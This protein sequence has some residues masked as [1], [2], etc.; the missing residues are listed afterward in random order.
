MKFLPRFTLLHSLMA[1]HPSAMMLAW[2]GRVPLV[3]VLA[4]ILFTHL[5]P[6]RPEMPLAMRQSVEKQVSAAMD[7]LAAKTTAA[8]AGRIDVCY[9]DR[10]DTEFTTT[11]IRRQMHAHG[12]GLQPDQPISEKLRDLLGLDQP[13][14]STLEQALAQARSRD[15]DAVVFG[16]IDVSGTQI[17]IDL[18]LAD[19]RTGSDM[20]IELADVPA[21]RVLQRDIPPIMHTVG[22]SHIFRRC[23]VWVIVALALP[24]FT[25]GFL[26]EIVRKESNWHNFFALSLYTLIDLLLLWLLLDNTSRLCQIV[27]LLAGGMAIFFYNVS[28]MTWALKMESGTLEVGK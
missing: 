2:A 22:D 5:S 16:K 13:T 21:T 6:H 15:L 19:A 23:V 27:S 4:W 10:D 25:V 11:E 20:K 18:R 12:I 3:L 9:L 28:V 8:H 7:D 14:A 26:R 17:K 1:G 24:I